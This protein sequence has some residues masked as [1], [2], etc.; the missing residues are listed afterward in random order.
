MKKSVLLVLAVLAALCLTGCGKEPASEE[1]IKADLAAELTKPSGDVDMTG[2]EIIKRQT[3]KKEKT[4]LVYVAVTYESPAAAYRESYALTYGL[5]NEGWLLDETEAYETESWKVEPLAGP[6]AEMMRAD[7]PAEAEL[8]SEELALEDGRDTATYRAEEEH[9]YCDV[10]RTWQVEAAFDMDTEQW[11]VG[12]PAEERAENWKLVGHYLAVGGNAGVTFVP[13]ES[14]E[15]DGTNGT[16]V[17]AV[18]SMLR[19]SLVEDLSE[20]GDGTVRKY[21]IVSEDGWHPYDLIVDMD[22][23]ATCHVVD[24]PNEEEGQDL[25]MVFMAEAEPG[26]RCGDDAVW[27]WDGAGTVTVSGSGPIW[28]SRDAYPNMSG[29]HLLPSDALDEEDAEKWKGS[30]TWGSIGTNGKLER[31]VIEEG[32]TTIGTLAFTRCGPLTSVELPESL[33]VI[34][35]GAFYSC[36]DMEKIT[37]PE[38]VTE[39]EE[40]AFE[41]CPAL[42]IYGKAGSAAEVYAAENGIPFVAE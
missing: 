23:G 15:L 36:T 7:I 17:G 42:T 37:I 1:D 4:D 11:T 16:I 2:M 38:S 20:Q 31:L 28:N 34:K 29:L 9:T 18:L 27:S 8:V 13:T 19:E 3:D 26:W 33:Q 24:L 10:T 12:A 35:T 22:E 5:Y 21:T 32:I 41:D 40:G 14:G 6:T 39:I 25:Q 30:V